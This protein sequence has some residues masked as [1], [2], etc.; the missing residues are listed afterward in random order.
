MVVLLF[1]VSQ[2]RLELNGCTASLHFSLSK[3]SLSDGAAGGMQKNDWTCY[4]CG[5]NNFKRRDV[6]FKCQTDRDE[7]EANDTGDEISPTPTNCLILRNLSSKSTADQILGLVSSLTN[8][9]IRSIRFPKDPVYNMPRGVCYLELHTTPEAIQL[10]ALITQIDT[11]FLVDSVPLIL[12]YAKRYSVSSAS[13][14]STAGA[15]S[16]ALAAAQWTNQ[17]ACGGDAAVTGGSLG[18]VSVNGVT[19]QKFRKPDPSTFQLES[20]S[21][22]YYDSTTRLYYD[23]KSSYYFN[24]MTQQYLYWS[25]EYETYLPPESASS[26]AAAAATEPEKEKKAKTPDKVKTAKKIAKD[27]EKWARTMNQKTSV[28]CFGDAIE[29]PDQ[30]QPSGSQRQ[31]SSAA[32]SEISQSEVEAEPSIDPAVARREEECKLIDWSKLLCLLCKRQFGSKDQLT[33]HQQLSDLHRSNLDS[34][35][36][37]IPDPQWDR[38]RYVDRAQERRNKWGNEEPVEADPMKE[39]YLKELTVEA[40]LAAS[41]V[42]EQRIAATNKGS[43]MLKAM[44]WKEGQGLGRLNKGRADIIHVEVRPENAGLGSTSAM[45]DVQLRISSGETY[46]DAVKKATAHRF[47]ELYDN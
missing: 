20:S 7:S 8:A 46:K 47:K 23:P 13:A 22:F 6:C 37:C 34:R 11:S 41:R 45:S 16:A 9:P 27:M 19:Y 21:G 10:M 39:L 1:H 14:A 4:K 29:S 28:R 33:K 43:K 42:S 36:R 26:S 2:G 3:D 17:T 35:M 18:A 25:D 5:V 32:V 38:S 15:A 44:G 31:E 30:S 40:T 24:S 12:N